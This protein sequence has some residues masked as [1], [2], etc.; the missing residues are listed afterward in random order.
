MD[1]HSARRPAWI[2]CGIAVAIASARL[3]LAVVKE[4]VDPR[5]HRR[6]YA[7][8]R[9]LERSGARLGDEVELDRLRGELIS[10]AATSLQSAHAT[11][12]LR[13]GTPAR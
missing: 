2:A 6:R 10:V 3:V 11:L 1:A 5:F 8:A 9:M 13:S 4:L 7:A 12:W